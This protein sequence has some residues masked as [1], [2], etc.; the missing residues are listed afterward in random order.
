MNYKKIVKHAGM[1]ESDKKIVHMQDIIQQKKEILSINFSLIITDPLGEVLCKTE[2]LLKKEHYDIRII[3]LLHMKKGNHYNPFL[4]I[5]NEMDAMLLARCLVENTCDKNNKG[6]P[7]W[8]RSEISLLT[9][10]ICYLKI[11]R[12]EQEQNFTSVMKM[13]R[14]AKTGVLDSLFSDLEKINSNHI[15][16]KQ[17]KIFDMNSE[18]DRGYVISSL[19]ARLSIFDI[20]QIEYLMETDDLS[21]NDIRNSK[22]ALFILIPIADDSFDFIIKALHFQ[23]L[24]FLNYNH[25][26]K[27]TLLDDLKEIECKELENTNEHLDDILVKKEVSEKIEA[28]EESEFWEF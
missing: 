7:S 27:F 25:N 2:N 6:N 4:Y 3:D 13:L 8:M 12:P 5:K 10:I 28:I 11:E 17:W 18:I 21:L 9:A 23:I 16:I 15:S 20:S 24:L 19:A 1:I 26:Y 14:A 22:I